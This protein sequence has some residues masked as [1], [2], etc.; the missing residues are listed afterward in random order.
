MDTI[1]PRWLPARLS[2]VQAANFAGIGIFMPFMPLWLAGRGLSE[3]MIGL[4]LTIPMLMRI[5]AAKPITALGDGARGPLPVLAALT[6]ISA[7]LYAC[8]ALAPGT[9]AILLVLA[10]GS[11]AQAGIIPLGDHVVLAHI[12]ERPGLDFGRIRLWGSV[13]FLLI[14]VAGGLVIARSGTWIIPWLIMLLTAL[15]LLVILAAPRPPDH[16]AAAAAVGD[17]PS[18]DHA[19]LAALRFAAIGSALIN[20]SHAMLYSFGSLYW[21][22]GGLGE[23]VIG[24]LWAI[25]VVA[26]ILLFFWLGPWA[27]GVRRGLVLLLISAL[28]AGLRFALMPLADGFLQSFALQILHAASFGCQ[29]LGVLAVAGALAAPGRT[30]AMLGSLTSLNALFMAGATLASGWLFARFG[31]YAFLAMVPLAAAGA[32]FVALAWQRAS[33]LLDSQPQGALPLDAMTSARAE[34]P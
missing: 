24:L 7:V 17:E 2:A 33:A 22:G 3:Q 23:D 26:E 29:L 6:A 9:P 13:S 16:R 12:R 27:R 11:V 8:L 31:G 14:N 34:Q 25:G 30:G 5:V 15:A 28:G 1:S 18:R 19:R 21:R 32:V 10:L 4:A 20:A